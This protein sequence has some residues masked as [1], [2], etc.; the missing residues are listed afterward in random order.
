MTASEVLFL[1]IIVGPLVLWFAH[2]VWRGYHGED[3]SLPQKPIPNPSSEPYP[4]PLEENQT[5]KPMLISISQD[6]WT[7]TDWLLN[8]YPG[9]APVIYGY[10][11]IAG[12]VRF[13]QRLRV[14]GSSIS[15]FQILLE[16]FLTSELSSS[17]FRLMPP[18]Q[19]QVERITKE[20]EFSLPKDA[21]VFFDELTPMGR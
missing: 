5:R 4:H 10:L 16:E 14:V 19:V 12:L 17:A 11:L 20:V 2:S 21:W 7:V 8:P 18:R 3:S 6:A 9:M 13:R 1:V 15:T